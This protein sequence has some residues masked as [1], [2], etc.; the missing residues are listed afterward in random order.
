MTPSGSGIPVTSRAGRVSGGFSQDIANVFLNKDPNQKGS[1]FLRALLDDDSGDNASCE[2][3]N[4][5][6]GSKLL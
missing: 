1:G 2:E 5:D 4:M 6:P 3:D